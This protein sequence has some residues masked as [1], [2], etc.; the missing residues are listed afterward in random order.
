MNK[1]EHA[2]LPQNLCPE[3]TQ[4][5]SPMVIDASGPLPVMWEGSRKPKR[6]LIYNYRILLHNTTDCL[7]GRGESS[8][9]E[10][11]RARDFVDKT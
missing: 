11:G 8:L 9:R 6:S 10:V 4:V 3:G 7:S 2:F 1:V 5:W